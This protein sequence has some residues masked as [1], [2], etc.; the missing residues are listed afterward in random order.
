MY[1]RH[2]NCPRCGSRDNLG[3]YADGHSWCFGCGHYIPSVETL[4]D[5]AS[6]I[7]RAKEI[8][9]EDSIEPM[10][11]D[12]SYDL[13]EQPTRWLKQYG[14]TET[15]IKNNRI[16][17]STTTSQL[18]FPIYG[19]DSGV[20]AWQAR[21]FNADKALKRKYYSVGKMDEILH[22]IGNHQDE[23]IILTEDIVS[24]IKVSR[25]MNAMPIFGAHISSNRLNRLIRRFNKLVVWLDY[26]KAVEARKA[27]LR[28]LQY[29][30]E[31]KTIHTE[32]DPKELSDK[33]IRKQLE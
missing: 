30:F 4:G 15:E 28:A 5:R 11:R 29:G 27:V 14:I 2:T 24:A 19:G 26:D 18:I 10:P 21:N 22:I 13:P 16:C 33:E 31:A 20:I 17:W 9:Y 6:K 7:S 1:V 3:V 23:T 25:H 32:L 8:A 12:I